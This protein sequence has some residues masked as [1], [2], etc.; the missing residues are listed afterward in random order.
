MCPDSKIKLNI[1]VYQGTNSWR[2]YFRNS[3][4]IRSEPPDLLFF[5]FAIASKISWGV[6]GLFSISLGGMLLSS[7]FV[8]HASPLSFPRASFSKCS[9]NISKESFMHCFFFT[10]CAEFSCEIK[11]FQTLFSSIVISAF[12][13][14]FLDVSQNSSYH[15]L[16]GRCFRLDFVFLR[17]FRVICSFL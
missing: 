6:K 11:V 9:L 13:Q 4:I 12:Y 14:S 1:L 2:E 16:C 10:F 7:P 5:S 17:D 3:F 15:G 8:S